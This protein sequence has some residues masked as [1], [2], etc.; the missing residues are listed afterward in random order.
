MFVPAGVGVVQYLDLLA[1]NGLALGLS[2]VASTVLTL[3]ATVKVFV[4][5]KQRTAS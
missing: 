2:L 3:L 1:R 4:W 5:V